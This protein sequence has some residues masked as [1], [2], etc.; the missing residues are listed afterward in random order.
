LCQSDPPDRALLGASAA[1]IQT[2]VNL[3]GAPDAEIGRPGGS[4]RNLV[5]DSWNVCRPARI[6]SITSDRDYGDQDSMGCRAP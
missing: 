5:V 3:A 4:D 1:L 6:S 2:V